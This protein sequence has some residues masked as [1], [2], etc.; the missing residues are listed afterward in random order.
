MRFVSQP[1]KSPRSHAVLGHV[2]I[3][4]AASLAVALAGAGCAA[5]LAEGGVAAAAGE[6]GLAAAGADVLSSEAVAG[7]AFAE[8]SLRSGTAGLEV[9]TS[10]E[11]LASRSFRALLE[12]LS[13]R[14][15]VRVTAGGMLSVAGEPL[16]IE[17]DGAI[18]V[19][20]R[21]VGRFS[22]GQLWEVDPAGDVSRPI[23]TIR[24]TTAGTGIRL[25]AGP[26]TDAEILI[27][28]R[29][30][31]AVEIIRVRGNW[32]E[33]RISQ[34][35]T[36]WIYGPLLRLTAVAAAASTVRP[37]P[38]T[39]SPPAVPAAPVAQPPRAAPDLVDSIVYATPKDETVVRLHSD[40]WSEAVVPVV[41]GPFCFQ[42]EGPADGPSDANQAWMRFEADSRVIRFNEF[43]GLS[44]PWR[45]GFR[46]KGP[47]GKDVI[48]RL[49]LDCQHGTL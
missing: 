46:F 48:V 25:R 38:G 7:R 8:L 24:G 43:A 13:G 26:S 16:V 2:A 40:R 3:A 12:E 44:M 37:V 32:F 22:E 35:R 23:G 1:K 28:L 21:I 27:A 18:V 20:R 31:T 29:R 45:Q 30:G 34:D 6:E 4:C 39:A 15:G 41:K 11:L 10:E 47:D 19:G 9:G 33:V 17:G 14:P 36:G 5:E 42:L 49:L